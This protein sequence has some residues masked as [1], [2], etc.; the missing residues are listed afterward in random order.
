MWLPHYSIEKRE[1]SAGQVFGFLISGP[2]VIACL[3][4]SVWLSGPG[5]DDVVLTAAQSARVAGEGRIVVEGLESAWVGVERVWETRPFHVLF[6]WML[7]PASNV[8]LVRSSQW[9]RV[10]GSFRAAVSTS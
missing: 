4:G 5:I 10:R 6:R 8:H 9:A 2:A 7:R 1:L 3:K